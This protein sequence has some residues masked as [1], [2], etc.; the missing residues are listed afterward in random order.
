MKEQ[1]NA[2]TWQI[3]LHYTR[4]ITESTWPCWNLYPYDQCLNIYC[5]YLLLTKHTIVTQHSPSGFSRNTLNLHQVYVIQ[6]STNL[7]DYTTHSFSKDE[8][9]HVFAT[10]IVNSLNL[11][12]RTCVTYGSVQEQVKTFYMQILPALLVYGK[13]INHISSMLLQNVVNSLRYCVQ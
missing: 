6:F 9:V 10:L 2:A 3:R 13:E 5:T 8:W 12:Y 4:F 7:K 1:I 11:N